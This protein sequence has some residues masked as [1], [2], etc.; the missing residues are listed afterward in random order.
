ML[1]APTHAGGWIEP[2]VIVDRLAAR[3]SAGRTP[4]EWFEL[5]LAQA[6][7]RMLPVRRDRALSSVR[8]LAGEAAA[9]I[10][11][12][13]GEEAA[14]GGTRSLWVAAAR[15]RNPDGDDPALEAAH[16]GLGPDGAFAGSF[17]LEFARTAYGSVESRLVSVPPV[18]HD[19]Y[20]VPTALLASVAAQQYGIREHEALL[21]WARL[22]WPRSRRGWF[23]TAS[24]L[25]LRNLDWWS[26]EWANRIRMEP[27]F[28]PWTAIGREAALLLAV[29]LQAK[30][31]GERG[32][33]VEATASL[34]D[35]GRLTPDAL[36]AACAELADL[37]AHQPPQRY[38]AAFLR[39]QR[40][41]TSLMQVAAT[42]PRNA[43]SAQDVAFR[44]LPLLVATAE[45][46]IFPVGQL[47]SLLRVLT[48]LVVLTDEPVPAHARPA[49]VRLA[50]GGGAVARLASRLLA[51]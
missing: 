20:D 33:A 28:E 51:A 15:C 4:P 38:P 11:Y 37:A 46:P 13:L 3:L 35:D 5:D 23:A 25:M 22:I 45:I 27:L 2:S 6:M 42:S 8:P 43:A 16:P 29:T 14:I 34:F 18:E 39:P 44:V 10:R 9:A 32:Y 49:L 7:L 26:A 41:A 21:D 50:G 24:M 47:A 31:P 48:E 17:R 12:A 30:E 40:L 36:V 1:A 19:R